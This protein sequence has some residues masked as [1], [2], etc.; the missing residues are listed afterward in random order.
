[1]LKKFNKYINISII[2]TL[3]FLA[4]GIL[5]VCF[6]TTSIKVIAIIIAILLIVGGIF[7]ISD[8]GISIF[9]VNLTAVGILSILMGIILLLYPDILV[10]LIPIVVGMFVIVNSIVDI[11]LSLVL[12]D[13]GYNMWFLSIILSILTI[14]CGI[15]IMINPQSS[16]AALTTI[17][18]ILVMVY[19]VAGMTNLII[20]K[21]NVNDIVKGFKATLSKRFAGMKIMFGKPIG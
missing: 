11:Q 15:I 10:I 3:L 8:Y 21:S 13:C 12:K 16:S 19:S 7:L 1:M 4:L 2:L 9:W 17:F 6:P 18:G 5:V 14:V 20:F